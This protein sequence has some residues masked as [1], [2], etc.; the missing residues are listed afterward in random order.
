MI[1]S[2]VRE[3]RLFH[4]IPALVIGLELCHALHVAKLKLPAYITI[5]PMKL[6]CPHCQA[7]PGEVCE[8]AFGGERELVH[9]ERI[10]AAAAMDVA[11]KKIRKISRH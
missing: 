10:K 5:S 2:K 11:A 7:N 1:L 8:T 3:L 4:C 9:V 6:V